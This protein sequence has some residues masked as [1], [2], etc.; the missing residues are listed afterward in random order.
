MGPLVD[1]CNARRPRDVQASGR[2][3]A[4]LLDH[5]LIT[6]LRVGGMTEQ[7]VNIE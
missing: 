7:I 6:K 5:E 4:L 2:K 3:H 1:F